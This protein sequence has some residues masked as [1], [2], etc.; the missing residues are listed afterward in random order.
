V[1][2]GSSVAAVEMSRSYMP[3]NGLNLR[4]VTVI[5]QRLG[6]CFEVKLTSFEFWCF[7]ADLWPKTKLKML[8]TVSAENENDRNQQKLSFL[9]PKTKFGRSLVGSNVCDDFMHLS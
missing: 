7:R 3:L 2:G 8:K 6:D 9:V 5:C 4:P 1:G